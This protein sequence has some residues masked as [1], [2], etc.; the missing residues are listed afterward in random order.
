M[1]PASTVAGRCVSATKK[2]GGVAKN[3]RDSIGQR[4]GIKVYG[5]QP[6]KAGGIIVR[7]LGNQF[8]PGSNVGMGKDYTLYALISGVVR[9]MKNSVRRRVD[10]L[11]MEEWTPPTPI[12]RSAGNRRVRA[13]LRQGMEAEARREATRAAVEAARERIR[14]AEEANAKAA[15]AAQ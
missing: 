6:V 4:R 14:A 7:Q 2:G 11:P 1:L 5:D 8:W 15:A 10:V 9:Y 13:R 12:P 3:G